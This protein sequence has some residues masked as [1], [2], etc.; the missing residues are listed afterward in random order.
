MMGVHGFP[1]TNKAVLV[2]DKSKVLLA[3]VSRRLL[4]KCEAGM[5]RQTVSAW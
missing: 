5:V 3:S 1:R 4:W 2:S